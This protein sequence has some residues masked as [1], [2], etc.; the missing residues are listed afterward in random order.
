MGF[1]GRAL[2]KWRQRS[3]PSQSKTQPQGHPWGLLP[4]RPRELGGVC[5]TKAR[6]GDQSDPQAELSLR[7]PE[8]AAR[9]E[10]ARTPRTSNPPCWAVGVQ[11]PAAQDVWSS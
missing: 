8:M 3:L 2:G 1:S 9:S 5:V 6:S 7:K 11:G 4:L 10:P